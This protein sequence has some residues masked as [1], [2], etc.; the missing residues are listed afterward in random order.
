MKKMVK[1][2][3]SLKKTTLKPS[4]LV[5]SSNIFGG[6]NDKCSHLTFSY[7]DKSS[8]HNSKYV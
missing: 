7:V 1:F 4:L 5:K 3:K 2:E 6:V 8:F